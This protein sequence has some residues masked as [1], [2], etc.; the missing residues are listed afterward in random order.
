MGNL[1]ERIKVNLYIYRLMN[2]FSFFDIGLA[3]W[4]RCQQITYKGDEVRVTCSV[5]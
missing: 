3:Q 1:N 2:E 4:S 5:F